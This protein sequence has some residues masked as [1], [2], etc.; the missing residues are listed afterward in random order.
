M[1]KF[2]PKWKKSQNSIWLSTFGD[3]IKG[4]N[5]FLVILSL[6]T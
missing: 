4:E 3:E 1:V 2:D 5:G 6:S